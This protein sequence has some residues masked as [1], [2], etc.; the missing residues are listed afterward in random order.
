MGGG[1]LNLYWAIQL[2]GKNR[3]GSGETLFPN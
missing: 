3:S 1:L 2:L